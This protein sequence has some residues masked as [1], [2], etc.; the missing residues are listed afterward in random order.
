MA[1]G[2]EIGRGYITVEVDEG[3]ARA[4]LRGFVS[5]AG[6]AFKTAVVAAGALTGAAAKVGIQFNSMQEQ[7]GVAFETLLGSGEKAQAFLVDLQ[8][9]AAKT[10]FELPGLINNARQ[11]LGVGVAANKVIPTMNALGNAA[12]ALGI[13]QERFNN[14]LLAT[15]QAMG[16]GKLQ[17][18]ELMQM[19]ENGIPVWQLLSKATGK[20]VTELQDLSSKGQLLAADTLPKLFDQMNKDYGGAMI[21][22]SQ[23]LSGMW[24][25]L[26]DNT[27]ILLGTAFKPLFN[28]TKNVT[29]ALGELASS[30][31]ATQF[32]NDFADG[33]ARGITAAKTFGLNVKA[34][35]GDTA[36]T[37]VDNLRAKFYELWPA[38]KD[39]ASDAGQILLTFLT[40]AAP[41]LLELAQAGSGLLRPALEAVNKVLDALADRAD[42]LAQAVTT[43][44]TVVGAVAA[45]AFKL[46]GLGI[47]VAGDAL[48]LLVNLVADLSGLLGGVT[49]AVLAGVVAWRAFSSVLGGV[50]GIW[51]KL[52]P[53]DVAEGLKGF[54]KNVDEA[55]LQA[56]V[57]TEKLTGSATAGEKVATAGS[58]VGTVMARV[59]SALPIV[60]LAVTAVGL[61]FEASAEQARQLD[62]GSQ[63]MAAALLRGGRAADE[64]RAKLDVFRQVQE[65]TAGTQDRFA[66]L[67][68]DLAAQ[69]SGKVKAAY[70]GQLASMSA[71]ERAQTLLTQAQNNYDDAVVKF[72]RSSPQAVSA[73][74]ALV[75]AAQG[76]EVAQREAATATKDHEQ[77][78]W[79]LADAALAQ[80]NADV[81]LRQAN[82]NAAE[83]QTAYTTAVKEHGAKS[84]EAQQ[85]SLNLEQSYI[86]AAD[87]AAKKATQDM[88]GKSASQQAAAATKAYNDK[89]IEMVYAAG[90]SAPPALLKMLTGL[91]DSALAAMN[92]AAET[93]GF[94]TKVVQLPDGRTVK[95]AVDD[96]G[97]PVL[98]AFK[99]EYDK[100]KNKTV[101]VNF[102]TTGNT[103]GAVSRA[104]GRYFEHASGGGF[105]PGDYG[106]VGEEGPELITRTRGGWVH[107]AE[108]TAKMLGMVAPQGGDGSTLNQYITPPPS[109]DTGQVADMVVDKMN[110][111][112]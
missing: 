75:A 89:L 10:P 48:A 94:R 81:A 92:A 46:M 107:D 79:D 17:G 87:A 103:A 50:Q 60:G 66:K 68:G 109:V 83:A 90:T 27:Q 106:L 40:T 32:A 16:K 76:V 82:L 44:A 91:D 21:K 24:S 108:Q 57:M 77:S 19:V 63:D 55:S 110:W 112:R 78:I 53:A 34:E 12:G 84:R 67:S 49:G 14:I 8:Q 26:K 96:K 71:V 39:G 30:D 22:Q 95:I 97:R 65:A 85:A 47:Q 43:A 18:E 104:G 86:R 64:A 42:D 98:D 99:R 37:A 6:S 29:G 11:L 23:T 45:P 59:G 4:A 105:G 1:R 111:R 51:S 7:A 31:R 2:V 102:V 13:D 5:F 20:S 58:K 70:D 54:T 100:L 36:Q 35:L 88:A 41:A 33:L 61:A 28:E 9:F 69:V 62:E 101:V 72:G 3:G 15:T 74:Q 93:A 52:N 56:G 80:A 73:Q 38:V 25:S